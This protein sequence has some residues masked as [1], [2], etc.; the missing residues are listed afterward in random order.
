M[1]RIASA[2]PS[3]WQGRSMRWAHPAG[4]RSLR[5]TGLVAAMTVGSSAWSASLAQQAVKVSLGDLGDHV[6]KLAGSRTGDH[7]DELEAH[8]DIVAEQLVHLCRH[9]C[10]LDLCPARP[11]HNQDAHAVDRLLHHLELL[12]PFDLSENVNDGQRV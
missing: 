7:I 4:T 11:G 12:D 8:V 5:C 9:G 1:V 2:K 10:G 3:L 6:S